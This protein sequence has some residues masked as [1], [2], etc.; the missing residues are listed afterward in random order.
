MFLFDACKH[1]GDV[2]A[3]D[4]GAVLKLPLGLCLC[5]YAV[6][7]D[8]MLVDE[9]EDMLPVDDGA[10]NEGRRADNDDKDQSPAAANT[11]D[12]DATDDEKQNERRQV[13]Q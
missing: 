13:W 10:H 3:Y 8:A 4:R 1:D 11:E 2:S 5:V 6:A 7:G 12:E 9:D